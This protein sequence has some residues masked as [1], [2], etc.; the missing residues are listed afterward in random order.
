[1]ENEKLYPK[2]IQKGVIFYRNV[3]KGFG[4]TD[5]V[6][7]DVDSRLKGMTVLQS[8]IMQYLNDG[9]RSKQ[10]FHI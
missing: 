4:D 8:Y 1:M 9:K 2:E 6:D 5:A 3:A 7:I 10:N